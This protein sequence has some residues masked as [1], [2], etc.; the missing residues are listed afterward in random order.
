MFSRIFLELS[1]NSRGGFPE[2]LHHTRRHVEEVSQPEGLA[3]TCLN[4]EDGPGLLEGQSRL[5]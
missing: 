4:F 5:S 3:A 2:E 1:M